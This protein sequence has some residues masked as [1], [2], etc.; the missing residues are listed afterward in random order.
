MSL[1]KPKPAVAAPYRGP[2]STASPTDLNPYAVLSM[3]Q[4]RLPWHLVDTFSHLQSRALQ[5][6]AEHVGRPGMHARLGVEQ[7]SHMLKGVLTLFSV[8]T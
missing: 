7:L 4:A 5:R 3:H 8:M 2:G 6:H 1:R